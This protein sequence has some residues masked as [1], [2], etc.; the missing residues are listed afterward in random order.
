VRPSDP[1]ANWSGRWWSAPALSQL[2]S[3]TRALS[4]L[5]AVRLAVVEDRQGWTGANCWP[6]EAHRR[7][8][9]YEIS[10]PDRWADLV[11][12]H[13]IEVT[14]SR[15]HDWWRVTGW[16]GTWMIPDWE[17]VAADYDAVHLTVGGYLTTAGRVLTAGDARTLLAGWDPDQTYWLTDVLRLTG[18]I[19]RWSTEGHGPLGWKLRSEA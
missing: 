6:L 4:G 7:S 14:W 8:T 16:A 15:R 3:T 10:G 17:A 11:A 13:P 19:T 1:S 5:G 9:T 12:N 18:Q 2:P